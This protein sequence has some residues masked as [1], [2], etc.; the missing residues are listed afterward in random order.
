MVA[1]GTNIPPMPN[2]ATDPKAMASVAVSG[3]MEASEPTKAALH[4]LLAYVLL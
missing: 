4:F 2:P 3:L 1:A